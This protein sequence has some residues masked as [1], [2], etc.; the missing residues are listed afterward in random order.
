MEKCP[1]VLGLG[2]GSWGSG[3][4]PV[5]SSLAAT[6][7][8]PL[9]EKGGCSCGLPWLLLT[10]SLGWFCASWDLSQPHPVSTPTRGVAGV[11]LG[12]ATLQAC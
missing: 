11:E 7:S 4:G 10:L 12:G 9:Q 8:V 5:S 1:W 6:F 3:E 2:V